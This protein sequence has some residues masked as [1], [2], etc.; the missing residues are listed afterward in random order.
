MKSEHVFQIPFSLPG[1]GTWTF[2]VLAVAERQ[3][4]SLLSVLSPDLPGLHFQDCYEGDLPKNFRA[5]AQAYLH[6]QHKRGWNPA[7]G[8][9]FEISSSKPRPI[10]GIHEP[11]I[12]LAEKAMRLA[13]KHHGKINHVRKYTG[14]PYINHPAAVVDLM[15]RNCASPVSEEMI[16]A[17]WLHD[18]VE[19]T[20]LN[21]VEICFECGNTVALL[22]Q[23]LT[24]VTTLA[25][26]N[27]KTRKAIELKR[28]QKISP[29][30]KTI[31]LA[32]LIDNAKSII[33]HDPKFAK[34]YMQEMGDLLEVLLDGDPSLYA[35]ASQI[36]QRWLYDQTKQNI[37]E[38]YGIRGDYDHGFTL[39]GWSYP[40]VR[41][42]D[43]PLKEIMEGFDTIMQRLDKETKKH[44][45][46][47]EKMRA[48]GWAIR[49]KEMESRHETMSRNNETLVIVKV[50]ITR[51][52]HARPEDRFIKF[53]DFDGVSCSPDFFSGLKRSVKRTLTGMF[54]SDEDKRLR[55]LTTNVVQQPGRDQWVATIHYRLTD[56]KK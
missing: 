18:T 50:D 26:G 25:D 15:V 30:A 14:E 4:N 20:G 19:D 42:N 2:S 48:R 44:Q 36:H 53:S 5:S 41:I 56:V 23:Q 31:K 10:Y 47:L 38:A 54:L 29:D 22:V 8:I 34:I 51:P 39:R 9:A 17:A 55:E 49:I 6:E 46:Y 11:P 16:A 1:L 45:Q 24:D 21:L 35:M 27:R 13:Q 43:P 12:S 52:E 40:P 33:E 3:K 28:I 7:S 32:D 37:G